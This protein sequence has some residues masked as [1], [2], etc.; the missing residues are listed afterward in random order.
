MLIVKCGD[1]VAKGNL[2]GMTIEHEKASADLWQFF[3]QDMP[4][5][6][7]SP[8]TQ[9]TVHKKIATSPKWAINQKRPL[10]L[11]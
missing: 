7:A 6:T 2:E 9:N 11:C 10:A 3:L 1:I 8:L 4:R 5:K